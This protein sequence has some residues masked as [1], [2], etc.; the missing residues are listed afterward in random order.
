MYHKIIARIQEANEAGLLST[1]VREIDCSE[2]HETL[3]ILI[4]DCCHPTR[5]DTGTRVLDFLKLLSRHR[6]F[7][8][9]PNKGPSPIS[10]N[11]NARFLSHLKEASTEFIALIK[12]TIRC[13]YDHYADEMNI[14]MEDHLRRLFFKSDAYY[15]VSRTVLEDKVMCLSSIWGCADNNTKTAIM[16]KSR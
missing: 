14:V 15:I 2:L 3:Q 9:G 12:R 11:L 1:D 8:I 7:D 16:W 4:D 5:L 13:F 6:Y 10:G